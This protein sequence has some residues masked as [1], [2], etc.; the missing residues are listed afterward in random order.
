M[1]A[2]GRWRKVAAILAV[3]K[4]ARLRLE[5]IVWYHEHGN[6]ASL[7]CRHYGIARKTFY[8]WY[9]LFDRNNLYSLYLLQDRPRIPK[10]VRK[11]ELTSNQI[12][13]II[14]LRRKYLRYSAKKLSVIFP[15]HYGTR[16]SAWHIQWVIQTYKLYYNKKKNTRVQNKRKRAQKK[17]LTI[18]LTRNLPYWQKR[19]GYIICLDTVEVILN[20]VKRYI[21]TAVDKYGKFAYARIYSTKSSFNGRDF[22]YRLYCLTDANLPR[23]GH[24]NGT[25]FEKYFKAACQELNIE[26]YYSRVRTPKDNP[27]NE[28]FNRTLQEEW[29]ELV[30]MHPDLREAN[31]ELTEW[32]VE[33]NY[34]RPHEALGYKTPFEICKVLPMYSRSTCH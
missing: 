7:A 20:S 26:Q 22:L 8:K 9:N 33:Y 3:S 23:V 21:F 24:D 31:K 28:R 19:A 2:H 13:E 32:L 5:W 1:D 16:M 12:L 6:N 11:T 18:D 34:R 17:K 10:N 14:A 30:G 4:E 27:N 29:L 15:S 25:E